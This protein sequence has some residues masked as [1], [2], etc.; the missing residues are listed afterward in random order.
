MF[1]YIYSGFS[2]KGYPPIPCLGS[3][4][5]V[6]FNG[7]TV[8]LMKYSA[9]LWICQRI[10]LPKLPEVRGPFTMGTPFPEFTW[11]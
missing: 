1:I 10:I 7:F 8:F 5:C 3:R 6:I 11:T 9:D 2:F 4:A